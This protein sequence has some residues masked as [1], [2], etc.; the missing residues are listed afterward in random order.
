MSEIADKAPATIALVGVSAILS[1][2]FGV[3][4]G[5][6]A[7]WRRRTGFDYAAT[8]STMTLYSMPDFWLGM[9]LLSFFA[10]SLGWFPIGGLED[11]TSTPPGSPARRPGEAHGPA[12]RSR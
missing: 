4:I 1:A 12:R 6:A 2:V 8:T 11:P 5:I 3:M 7:A 9:L 10:V